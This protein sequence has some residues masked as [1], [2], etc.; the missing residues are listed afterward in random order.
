MLG[1]NSISG[2]ISGIDSQ[3]LVEQLILFERRPAFLLEARMARE[4]LRLAS[5][6][7]MQANLE[8][9]KARLDN[10]RRPSH[11]RAMAATSS[12]ADLVSVTARDGAAAGSYNLSVQQMAQNHQVVSEGY[13]A[14]DV[15]LGTGTVSVSLAG[16]ELLSVTLSEGQDS[17]RDL[18][19]AINAENADVT[20]AIV[21][22]GGDG[23]PYQLILTGSGTGEDRIL[24]LSSELSGGA[25]LEVG[26]VG[27][28]VPGSMAG[29]SAV[30]S[31]GHYTGNSDAVYD[32]SVTTGGVVGSDAIV[33]GWSND[34]GQSG[35]IVLPEDY[36]GEAVHVF[37]GLELS[38]GAGDL[39]AGDD[40]SV[41]TSSATIQAAQDAVLH[42]GSTAGGGQPLEVRNANNSFDNLIAGVT[43]DLHGADPGETITINVSR[44]LDDL[45]GR[46]Q[47]FVDDYNNMVDYFNN[48][49]DYNE[50]AQTSGILMGDNV[51]MR[52]DAQ[53][54]NAVMGSVAGLA[55]DLSHLSQIGIGT[56]V[57]GN[58]NQDGTLSLDEETLRAA[59]TDDLEG[60]IALLG[61]TGEASDDDIR[62][63]NAGSAARPTGADANYGVTITQAATR[64]RF[65]GAS[66][67]APSVGTP[68]LVDSG[69]QYLKVAVDGVSSGTLSLTEGSYTSGADLAA[70][71]QDLINAD[72]TLGGRD[73]TVD[74]V[75][76]GGGMG[77]LEFTSQSYGG[78]SKVEFED[79][80]GSLMDDLG[81]SAGSG[82][83]GHDVEGYFT[84][85]GEI[86]E[87]T[88][89][90]RILT[91]AAE[92]GATRSLSVEVRLTEAMLASQ[93]QDQGS[94]Q[95]FSGVMDR[96]H[97]SLDQD[98]DAVDG[99]VARRQ[100]GI[101]NSIDEYEA[102]IAKIDERLEMRRERYLKEFMRMENLLAEMN[103]TSSAFQSMLASIPQI[104]S[105]INKGQGGS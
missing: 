84:V 49:F 40:W 2:I 105:Q 36:A 14:E 67:A 74:W 7:I 90:G 55:S 86:E 17:L 51:A 18:A 53:L 30:T 89:S 71:I 6:D 4:D 42:F 3:S 102:E 69:N 41:S 73:A 62:F 95:I 104:G 77:H 100:T 81:L 82:L 92:G 48:Q 39:Q 65:T 58:L 37:G 23:D 97:R 63:L 83:A 38:F 11:F 94:V 76:D 103:A 24:T 79:V 12:H 101:R 46:L 35:E 54:R 80:D 66:I 78:S 26:S 52:L 43:L 56:A 99:I 25:G 68:F 87:A 45:V 93:G 31:A 88:G 8:G 21:N 33:I 9:L 70:H 5:Y 13:A 34:Q 72:E 22:N 1:I 19:D 61:S 57:G 75:D 85:D 27:N 64:G 96:L 28:V 10:L 50:E 47:G 60:V 44:D 98:L 16:V 29:S 20:A 59:L 15:A 32:F 91:G